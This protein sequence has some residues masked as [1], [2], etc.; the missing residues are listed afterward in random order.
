MS[1]LSIKELYECKATPSISLEFFPPKTDS[2]TR[3]LMERMGR[4]SAM[5]PLFITV[6]WGAGGTTSDKT[7]NLAQLISKE[8]N[9]PVCMHLTCTNMERSVIDEALKKC[10]EI[11]IK[12]ILALRGD[13]PIGEDWID[14]DGNPEYEF[15]HA[16]DL[17]RYIKETYGSEFC[18]GVAAYPE[19]HYQEDSENAIQDPVKDLVYLK[20]KIDAG[21]DF[22]ITQM[23]YDV[24]RFLAFEQLFR[25]NISMNI[26]LFPGL[27]PI[28]SYLLFQRAS[29]L[30]HASIP[31][32]IL[33][34]FP[35]EIQFD[36]DSVKSIGVEILID[37]IEEI[38]KRT[39]GR[40]R[41]FHFY[42]LNLEKAIAQ[43]VSQSP[44]LS[45][46]LEENESSSDDEVTPQENG[47]AT[48]DADGDIVIEDI[49]ESN[50]DD[51][52]EIM[53][54]GGNDHGTK[55]RRRSSTVSTEFMMNRALVTQ[56][57]TN[58]TR[59]NQGMVGAP[60][61]K[62]VIS[63]SKGSGALGRDATWDEFPNGRFG[64]SRSPAYGE[65]D[66]YGST[67]KV[68]TKRAY[69]LWG[70]PKS[71]KDLKSI[72][73]KYLE[74]SIDALPWCDLGLSAETG[75]IQEELIQLNHRGYLTLASQPATNGSSSTDKIFGW[76]P[77]K[78]I[79]YQKAF[80][81]M[82]IHKQQW[83]NVLKPKIEHYGTR[84]FSY[85]AGDSSGSFESNLD[86]NSSNVVTW[87]VFP[88]SQVIQTTIIEEN[89]FKAWRDEAFTIWSEW[90]K[91]FPRNS[92][93][94]IFLREMFSEYCLISIVHHD[95]IE[96]D[97]LWD[98][99]LD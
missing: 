92:V 98:I 27:M 66:G 11:G 79:V 85:Y 29:K 67:I 88:N 59:T 45:H 99:L 37:I 56:G 12:N 2:G 64:D 10:Q 28:N 13:P 65:I 75:L 62:F 72:F 41:C 55:R 1:R 33:E 6:T 17:V 78:G 57:R 42:T 87:G 84:K 69:E 20:E 58:T 21:A 97:E 47:I 24:E 31:E 94:N 14:S 7:L 22:V 82:F 76:G 86:A 23:F 16:I 91:I 9:V 60:S 50:N 93:T 34:R 83:E 32:K 43:I 46:I 80:V 35:P 81:E 49:P 63:I 70:Q 38:Y 89:S 19:G 36:D 44:T 96:T 74:G 68:S 30:S 3:N 54:D 95:Y 52:D 71:L 25:D 26:P 4:M 18:I 8:F 53:I 39:S 48:I 61:K 73:I 51:S 90:A 15:K 77:K 5:D 40:V